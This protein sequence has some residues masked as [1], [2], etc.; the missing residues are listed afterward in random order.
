MEL[1]KVVLNP[2]LMLFICI[3]IGFILKKA[4]EAEEK[5]SAEKWKNFS[6]TS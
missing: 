5:E 4:K 2:M 6:E 3:I 1:F